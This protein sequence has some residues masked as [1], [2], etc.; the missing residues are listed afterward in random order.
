MTDLEPFRGT[1]GDP[2]DYFVD[3]EGRRYPL[4]VRHSDGLALYRIVCDGLA[5]I[6]APLPAATG[7][8]FEAAA[9]RFSFSL[10]VRD[11]VPS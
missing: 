4:V 9:G 6:D 8:G 1:L 10:D 3:S 11:P 5:P 7:G 2:A